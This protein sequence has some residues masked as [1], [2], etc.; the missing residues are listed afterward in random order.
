[1]M[2]EDIHAELSLLL[3]SLTLGII[4]MILYDV[5]RIFRK[6]IRHSVWVTALEDLLY[7]IICGICIFIMLYQKNDGKLRWFVVAGISVG[8]LMY[9]GTISRLLTDRIANGLKWFFHILGKVF[10]VVFKPVKIVLN[11]IKKCAKFL[12]KRGEKLC[13]FEKKR[14]KKLA[15]RVKIIVSKR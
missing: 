10:G 6:L 9:N 2:N 15:K 13:L 4:I 11:L 12:E 3:H 8:M 1:M 14:L 5:L 7:W